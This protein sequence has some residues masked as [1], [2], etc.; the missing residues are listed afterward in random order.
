MYWGETEGGSKG[1]DNSLNDYSWNYPEYGGYS[2]D[3][4]NFVSQ[5]LNAGEAGFIEDACYA[6]SIDTWGDTYEYYNDVGETGPFGN[7][8]HTGSVGDAAGGVDMSDG[9]G[10]MGWPHEVCTLANEV[11]KWFRNLNA[12]EQEDPTGFWDWSWEGPVAS[13]PWYVEPGC[14]YYWVMDN[15]QNAKH[16]GMVVAGAGVNAYYTAHTSNRWRSLTMGAIDNVNTYDLYIFRNARV[17]QQY[18]LRELNTIRYP[19]NGEK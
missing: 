1:D 9:E 10:S 2:S 19:K 16:V 17:S 15:N 8:S 11:L 7:V 18:F 6:P 5:L 4:A 14:F 12:N 3:C 13:I